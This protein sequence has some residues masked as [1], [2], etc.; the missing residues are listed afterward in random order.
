M[1]LL[2]VL[3]TIYSPFL[4]VA[5][6]CFTFGCTSNGS[7]SFNIVPAELSDSMAIRYL[8]SI[9]WTIDKSIPISSKGFPIAKKGLV[10][11]EHRPHT[12]ASGNLIKYSVF[13]TEHD[14]STLLEYFYFYKNYLIKVDRHK[15]GSGKT[16]GMA[17]YIFRED[18]L[19]DSSIAGLPDISVSML[20]SRAKNYQRTY[21]VRQD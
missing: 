18:Q 19:I 9:A 4:I 10:Y 14:T 15:A 20:L 16:I 2:H 7:A 3:R 12:D 21:N 5:N 11:G 6:V 13:L 17:T 1:S 8:D